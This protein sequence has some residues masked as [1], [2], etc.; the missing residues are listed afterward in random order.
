MQKLSAPR[1]VPTLMLLPSTAGF[2]ILSPRVSDV[3]DARVMSGAP[4][5]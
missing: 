1:Y 3:R 4:Q 5:E 2:V